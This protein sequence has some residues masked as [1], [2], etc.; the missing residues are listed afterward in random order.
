MVDLVAIIL[1][2]IV[3]VPAGLFV[4]SAAS[5]A[6]RVRLLAKYKDAFERGDAEEALRIRTLVRA[7]LP[8]G[9]LTRESEKVGLGEM[10]LLNEKWA[11]ARD[12]LLKVDR[13]LL[14]RKTRPGVLS[15]LAWATAQAGEPAR[16]VEL[17][18]Q[19]LAEAE[20]QGA[21]YPAEKWPYLRGTHGVALGLA[22]HHEEAVSWLEPLI[23][24]E[25]PPR[26]RAT[27][28]FYLGQSQR[29][30]GRFAEAASA[31]EL[32]T[33]GSGPYADRARAALRNLSPHR[34]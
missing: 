33:K 28:A 15:N 23:A 6:K 18:R 5:H 7:G 19:A 13:S 1:G 9:E 17:V 14:P 29:A 20:E 32:A 22:G 3:V 2:A 12:F 30:L 24:I 34:G 8:D 27:R 16:A 31:Y 10:C 21:A 26:A 4:S 25:H 11:E